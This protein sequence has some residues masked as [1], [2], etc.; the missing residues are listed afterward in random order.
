MFSWK[1]EKN[2]SKCRLLKIVP[3]VLIVKVCTS[4]VSINHNILITNKLLHQ[5]KLRNN[6][7]CSFCGQNNETIKARQ[8]QV[9]AT[10]PAFHSILKMVQ[11]YN[12]PYI[13]YTFFWASEIKNHLPSQNL[14]LSR[15]AGQWICQALKL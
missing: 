2:I 12:I 7:T 4:Q 8:I 10:C 1:N 9:S 5:M 13:F 15:A 11:N 14:D 3:N 6:A